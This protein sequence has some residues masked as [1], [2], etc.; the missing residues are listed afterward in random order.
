MPYK[1][2]SILLYIL[3]SYALGDSNFYNKIN[4]TGS[5][6]LIN[7][8]TARIYDKNSLAFNYFENRYYSGG[9]ILV[10]LSDR[11]E[12]SRTLL[13]NKNEINNV[14]LESTSFKFLVKKEGNFPAIAL[15]ASFNEY[16]ENDFQYIVSSY[17]IRNFDISFGAGW[18]GMNKD[19]KYHNPLENVSSEYF[20]E[21][22]LSF[23]GGINLVLMKNIGIMLEYDSYDINEFIGLKKSNY[24]LAFNGYINE[25]FTLAIFA[26]ENNEKGLSVEF[27]F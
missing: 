25:H 14:S 12:V 9:S 17:G 13:T 18:G 8:P 26:N 11:F 27:K 16:S 10:S 3:S 4:N 23:F 24:N 21:K 7:T 19:K 20:D 15:G 22:K 1:I 5:V 2:I 6:G